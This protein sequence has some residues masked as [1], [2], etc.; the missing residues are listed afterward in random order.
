[1]NDDSRAGTA[2]ADLQAGLLNSRSY[3]PQILVLVMP[4]TTN[5]PPLK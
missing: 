4:F 5:F 1:M 3:R 2:I